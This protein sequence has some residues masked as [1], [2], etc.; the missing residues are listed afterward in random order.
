MGNPE[1]LVYARKHEDSG[2]LQVLFPSINFIFKLLQPRQPVS[3]WLSE[4]LGIRVEGKI[5]EID[6]FMNLVIDDII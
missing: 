4:Q 1:K 6:E 3:T 5:R 2:Y